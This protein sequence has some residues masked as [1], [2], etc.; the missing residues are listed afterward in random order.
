MDNV[1][2]TATEKEIFEKEVEKT[3][4]KTVEILN[5]LS[6][7]I[8]CAYTI[9]AQNIEFIPYLIIFTIYL[10]TVF[11]INIPLSDL[12]DKF[13][14]NQVK[15]SLKEIKFNIIYVPVFFCI[16]MNTFIVLKPEILLLLS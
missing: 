10:F 11:G 7:L 8:I 12:E 3:Y 9:I 2:I 1:E 13:K 15:P 16:I 5:K 14:N 4:N 6:I